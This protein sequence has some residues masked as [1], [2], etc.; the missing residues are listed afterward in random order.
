MDKP[1]LNLTLPGE[2]NSH[3]ETA[4]TAT[5]T[6]TP[7]PEGIATSDATND[8]T[9]DATSGDPAATSDATSGP[10]RLAAVAGFTAS[11]AAAAWARTRADVTRHGGLG[12]AVVNGRGESIGSIH[13]YAVTRGWLP[14][15][16]PGGPLV[17]G[18]PVAYYHTVG[19]A[20][21]ALGNG[22]AWTFARMVRFVL[23]VLIAGVAV[24]IVVLATA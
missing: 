17:T 4:T 11:M 5:A 9:N 13:A 20:G 10:A 22:I 12:H 14:D 1:T 21:V 2:R 15:D 8:A 7:P 16:H 18:V 3:R 19:K 6:A 23:A 24:L